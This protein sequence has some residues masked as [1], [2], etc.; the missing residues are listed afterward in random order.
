[1]FIKPT[2]GYCNEV[3]TLV[4]ICTALQSLYP[5]TPYNALRCVKTKPSVLLTDAMKITPILTMQILT[6][7]EPGLK[8]I[9]MRLVANHE[10]HLFRI[11]I[12]VCP[13][14]T[15]YDSRRPMTA[16]HFDCSKWF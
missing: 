15:L 12:A 9:Q 14:C 11:V 7:T 2:I 5:N 3:L 10:Y 1:M 6:K 8:S 13:V 16:K 4:K